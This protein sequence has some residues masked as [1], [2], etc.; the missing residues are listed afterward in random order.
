MGFYC[1]DHVVSL[2]NLAALMS[3]EN[4]VKLLVF[5]TV[6]LKVGSYWG[7]FVDVICIKGVILII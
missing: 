4:M 3:R 5:L 7:F 6:K 2:L 1:N